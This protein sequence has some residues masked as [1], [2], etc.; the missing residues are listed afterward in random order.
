MR[1]G[2]SKLRIDKTGG[3]YQKPR[4]ITCIKKY[5]HLIREGKKTVE[6]RVNSPFYKDIRKGS[7]IRLFYVGNPN[8]DVVCFV[9]NVNKYDTFEEMLKSEGISNC[10]P[11]ETD[12]Q[13]AISVYKGIPGYA[14]KG[15]KYGVLA[16]Q[17]EVVSRQSE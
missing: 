14:E 8:D 12:L 6:G 4:G 7:L 2:A 5:I 15:D 17:V 1:K 11:N 3:E 10:L 9:K 13:K 16:F